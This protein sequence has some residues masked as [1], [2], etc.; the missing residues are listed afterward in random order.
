MYTAYSDL[1]AENC[2]RFYTTLVLCI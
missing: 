2:W 1:L